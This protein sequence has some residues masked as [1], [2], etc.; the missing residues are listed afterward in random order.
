MNMFGGF[1]E[2]EYEYAWGEG[3]STNMFG[4]FY[5]YEYVL[6]GAWGLYVLR[7]SQQGNKKACREARDEKARKE[8]RSNAG[9]GGKLSRLL[10]MLVRFS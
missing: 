1:Y 4:G 9:V 10:L 8:M 6:W 2:Y 3:G 5:E 7:L